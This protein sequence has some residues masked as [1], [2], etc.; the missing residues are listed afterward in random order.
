[1][2]IWAR[3]TPTLIILF[4]YKHSLACIAFNN[5]WF[6]KNKFLVDTETGEVL[7]SV[8]GGIDYETKQDIPCTF[9]TVQDPTILNTIRTATETLDTRVTNNATAINN[10][11]VDTDE[12][13]MHLQEQIDSL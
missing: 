4:S 2:T 12:A 3:L 10:N 7:C 5:S 9:I 13:I 8:G 11:K 6:G 1:M